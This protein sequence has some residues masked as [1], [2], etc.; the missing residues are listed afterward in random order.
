MR[1]NK[2]KIGLDFHG[3]INER[4]EYFAQ[5]CFAALAKGYEIHIITGGPQ[6][7][8]A[9]ILDTCNIPYTKIFAI[10]DYYDALGEVE[11]F[12]NGEFKI[13]DKL[14]DSAKA[15]YCSHNGINIHIDDSSH[16]AKWFS[17]PFCHYYGDENKCITENKFKIDFSLSAELALQEIE[18]LIS[19][20]QYS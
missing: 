18:K 4:P 16:Y 14:W 11:H 5:F 13:D 6:D 2:L 10:R 9:A 7:V 19:T 15:E 17:T 1:K 3:V 20:V 12:A 8:V